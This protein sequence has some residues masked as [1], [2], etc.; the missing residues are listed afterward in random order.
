MVFNLSTLF[1]PKGHA[2]SAH[3]LYAQTILAA[4]DPVPFTHWG[5]PDTV[6]GRFEALCLRAFVLLRRL[7]GEESAA[8]LSQAYFDI[9]FDDMDANLRELGVGD[10]GVGKKVKKLAGG[11]YGR[12]RAYD[13]GLDAEDEGPL[14]DALRRFL[15][16]DTA[17]TDQI[18]AS[19]AGFV[20]ADVALLASQPLDAL[21]AGRVTFK[22]ATP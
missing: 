22:E 12:I 6:E 2:D 13:T 21:A 16:R 3:K 8:E 19:A 10:M 14:A 15:F 11:F 5:V 20:R 9:M 18:V 17:V 4:R 7:K 1:R